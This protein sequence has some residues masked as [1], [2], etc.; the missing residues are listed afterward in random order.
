MDELDNRRR[1]EA[2][3]D[4][5]ELA[6]AAICSGALSDSASV[7]SFLEEVHGKLLELSG[8][9]SRYD[10]GDEYSRL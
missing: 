9:V 1:D 4:A 8:G 2:R 5:V 3:R 7:C 10:V 6:K